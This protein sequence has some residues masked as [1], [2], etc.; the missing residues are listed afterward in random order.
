MENQIPSKNLKFFLIVNGD[1]QG[2]YS[3]DE[4]KNLN[5]KSVDWIWHEGLDNWIQAGEIEELK[6]IFHKITPP[7][8]PKSE[9][10]VD[11]S[12][13]S[14]T[15]G[16]PPDFKKGNDPVGNFGSSNNENIKNPTPNYVKNT[17]GSSFSDSKKKIKSES[18]ISI[19]KKWYI[20]AIVTVLAI[21]IYGYWIEQQENEK[22][23]FALLQ[24]EQALQEHQSKIAAQELANKKRLEE[25][26]AS[27]KAQ[28]LQELQAQLNTLNYELDEAEV[29]L[30]DAKFKLSDIQQ[31]QLLRTQSE[32]RNQVQNQLRIIADWEKEIQRLKVDIRNIKVEMS[33]LSY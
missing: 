20:G 6:S 14:S 9:P 13:S 26:E 24:Q 5:I 18:F 15:F 3:I 16:T 22:V 2:P 11:S 25:E 31:F 29:Y 7:P 28:R 4:L 23:R 8:F 21:L 30:Q 1:S 10:N 19:R 12:S 17:V 32:K 27:R 33:N